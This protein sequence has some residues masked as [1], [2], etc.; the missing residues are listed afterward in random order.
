MDLKHIHR[1]PVAYEQVFSHNK[2][3]G[4]LI[5]CKASLYL[6]GRIHCTSAD[7][8]SPTVTPWLLPTFLFEFSPPQI[9]F[10]QEEAVQIHEVSLLRSSTEPESKGSYFHH[11]PGDLGRLIK[12]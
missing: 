2:L 3:E 10:T 7:V 4:E 6:K 8:L 1:L 5:P 12:S 9:N 11:T